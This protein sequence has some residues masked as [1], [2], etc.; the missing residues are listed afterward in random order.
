[1]IE[2]DIRNNFTTNFNKLLK[3]QNKKLSDLAY[4]LDFPNSTLYDWKNGKK[5]PRVD[6]IETLASYF[7]VPYDYFF[8][9][10]EEKEEKKKSPKE[11]FKENFN[12]LMVANNKNVSNI[13]NDLEIPYTTIS[14][15]KNGITF[16]RTRR[17]RQ[18]ADYFSVP[19]TYF[20]QENN[21]E[22]IK[23]PN[24]ES[25][26]YILEKALSKTTTEDKY[27]MLKLIIDDLS[28]GE[29]INARK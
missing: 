11:L 8:K 5:V 19:Y 13:S 7:N 12:A 10:A 6:N 15:W 21:E 17:I 14:D 16:P 18:L 28:K 9:K 23:N 1:M 4:D 25:I 20:F 27:K 24:E 29:N 22:V 26:V 2:T 3:K